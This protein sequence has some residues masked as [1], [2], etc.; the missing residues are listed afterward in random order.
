MLDLVEVG[1][2]HHDALEGV[3]GGE[4]DV[5]FALAVVVEGDVG[6]LLVF[7]VDAV[8]VFGDGVDFDGLAEGVVVAGLG[9]GGFALAEFLDDLFNG[10]AGGWGGVERAEAGWL[11]R[12]GSVWNCDSGEGWGGCGR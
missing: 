7:A 1:G 11:L 10:D 5:L 6:D 4:D 3:L 2:G 8:G 12:G 9:E